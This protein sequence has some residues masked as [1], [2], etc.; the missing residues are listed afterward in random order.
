MS[1]EESSKV[2]DC[3]L[4][5]NIMLSDDQIIEHM[6]SFN[7]DRITHASRSPERRKFLNLKIKDFTK[8]QLLHITKHP[9]YLNFGRKTMNFNIKGNLEKSDEIFRYKNYS[10]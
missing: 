1:D 6:P 8:K 4:I 10:G 7:L 3:G 5:I 2:Q 9:D